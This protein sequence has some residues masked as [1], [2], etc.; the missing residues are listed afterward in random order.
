MDMHTI[1]E[2]VLCGGNKEEN[3]PYLS[4]VFFRHFLPVGSRVRIE[5]LKRVSSTC[6]SH[7]TVLQ[8]AAFTGALVA[9]CRSRIIRRARGALPQK[10]R[11]G[12]EGRKEDKP[13]EKVIML[14]YQ[15]V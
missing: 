2:N 3:K 13:K 5:L 12:K 9:A 11:K 1:A 4:N 7:H 6:I 8:G 10:R 15:G 14:R